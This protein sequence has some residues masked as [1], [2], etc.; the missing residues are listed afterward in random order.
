MNIATNRRKTL[1]SLFPCYLNQYDDYYD[2]KDQFIEDINY[3]LNYIKANKVLYAA[4]NR[5]N[6]RYSP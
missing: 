1:V 5:R 2:A 4:K 6:S 3:V